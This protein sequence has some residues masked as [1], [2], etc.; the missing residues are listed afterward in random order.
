MSTAVLPRAS[1]FRAAAAEHPARKPLAAAATLALLAGGLMF[2][3]LANQAGPPNLEVRGANATT[4]QAISDA[5]GARLQ[6]SLF[7]VDLQ[8][9]EHA[10]AS[11][12]WVAEADVW[13][14][15][16]GT[17]VARVSEHR[18]VARWHDSRLISDQGVL[19]TPPDMD[20][21]QRLPVLSGPDE[22]SADVLGQFL[23]LEPAFAA[24]SNPLRALA[25]DARGSWTAT[26]ADGVQVHLGRR[27]I[28]ARAQRLVQV[29]VPALDADWQ[30]VASIDLRYSN[31]FAVAWRLPATTVEEP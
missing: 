13:R 19:F 7:A 15:F 28:A 3:A 24:V 2:A 22:T 6:T 1:A 9:I 11:L 10:L 20:G 31:G 26:L 4:A 14:R 25:I 21:L 12:P 27:D 30:R 29:A 18:V 5:I 17:V 8:A 23:V 16:P